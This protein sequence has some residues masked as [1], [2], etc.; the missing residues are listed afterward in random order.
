VGDL[1]NA[2]LRGI[3]TGSIYAI[4]GLGLN[5]IFAA[6]GVFNFAQ[7]EL[8]MVGAMLGVTLWAASGLP[9]GLALLAVVLATAAIG[10]L[11]ELLAV[12]RLANQRDATLWM[13]STLGVA[14]IVRSAATLLATRDGGQAQRNFPNYVRGDPWHL[15]DVS[16]VPQRIILVPIAVVLTLAVWSWFRRTRSGRGLLAMAAGREGAAMRGLPV[17]ILAVVAFALGGAIAGF[18]GFV[19][20]PIT[21]ASTEIGFGLTLSAFIA[22]TIGGI[23]HLWGPLVGGAVLG[24][25]QQLTATYLGS[26]LQTPVSLALLLVVLTL[27]PQGVLGR[28]VR[29]L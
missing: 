23:P 12:R 21:Q 2:L 25:G 8:V 1:L 5:V 7:G 18:G 29:T 9:L 17:G 22:A 6:T 24:I 13:L 20:G 26:E 16:I 11:T 19:G 3:Q 15:G 28:Q 27:R 10:A 4:V 14:I